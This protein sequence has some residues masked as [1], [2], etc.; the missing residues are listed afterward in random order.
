MPRYSK[1]FYVEI[2]RLKENPL[3][4][5]LPQLS[6]EDFERL[7]ESLE[8]DNQINPVL[9]TKDFVIIAGHQRV[10]AAKEL[11]WKKIR[12]QFIIP[13]GDE[14]E[15]E[16]ER[17]FYQDNLW[18]KNWPIEVLE[19]VNERVKKL[20]PLPRLLEKL[21]PEIREL[22][23]QSRLDRDL[24][25]HI[26]EMPRQAQRVFYEKIRM[27]F[28]V[29]S[30]QKVSKKDMERFDSIFDEHSRQ[31]LEEVLREKE[32]LEKE[33]LKQRLLK[34]KF[35]KEYLAKERLYGKA[36]EE[37]IALEKELN[38]LKEQIE[39][40]REQAEQEA[41]KKIEKT[42][43]EKEKHIKSLSDA[44]E[45]LEKEK[46]EFEKRAV[47][48][49][50]ALNRLKKEVEQQVN[51]NVDLYKKIYEERLKM[52]EEKEKKLEEEKKKMI[53]RAVDSELKDRIEQQKAAA[54]Q[55][56]YAVGFLRR[57]IATLD[58]VSET[59]STL[60]SLD[61]VPP[62]ADTLLDDLENT[63]EQLAAL[64]EHHLRELKNKRRPKLRI[65][66][67]KDGKKEPERSK[68]EADS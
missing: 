20:A 58:E 4:R 33:L 36:L 24:I 67:G 46:I 53:S 30:K 37:K 11:G 16:V 57:A 10:R 28:E 25:A 31:Q 13:E 45:R 50:D 52:L 14:A 6:R 7:K 66:G 60:I 43:E 55:V 34:E 48:A 59:V 2:D 17:V 49:E 29:S 35:E 15:L 8:V 39:E 63:L 21:T 5:E 65:V 42:I 38:R 54:R 18:G 26:S 22:A 32:R 9:I 12:A 23:E 56:V 1:T 19:K 44:I 27:F 51:K 62:A 40:I 68:T 3:N 64:A 61:P 47:I 41:I